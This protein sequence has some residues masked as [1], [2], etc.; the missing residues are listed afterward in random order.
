MQKK[1]SREA[2]LR[3]G[4]FQKKSDPDVIQSMTGSVI[5]RP[6]A[7][8]PGRSRLSAFSGIAVENGMADVESLGRI[9]ETGTFS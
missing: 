5:Y 9:V 7:G 8:L 4:R 1:P 2:V 6:A 3:G